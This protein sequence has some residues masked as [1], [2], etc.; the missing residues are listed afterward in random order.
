MILK[1]VLLWFTAFMV[2]VTLCSLDLLL[3][4][5]ILVFID[6]IATNCLLLTMCYAIINKEEFMILSGNRLIAKILKEE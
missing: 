3:N 5:S 6:M 1:G 4:E 2:S